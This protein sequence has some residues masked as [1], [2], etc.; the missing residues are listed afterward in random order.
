M[1]FRLVLRIALP[2]PYLCVHANSRISAWNLYLSVMPHQAWMMNAG[3]KHDRP[4]KKSKHHHHHGHSDKHHHHD[5]RHH[6]DDDEKSKKKKVN[7]ISCRTDAT[8]ATLP[9]GFF[10][11]IVTTSIITIISTLLLTTRRIPPSTGNPTRKGNTRRLLLLL[12]L[13]PQARQ[14]HPRATP[15]ISPY[16]ARHIYPTTRLLP[17]RR[18]NRK[19]FSRFA[20]LQEWTTPRTYRVLKSSNPWILRLE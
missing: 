3:G 20:C 9:A 2:F 6:H 11:N 1:I 5:H 18:A 13:L 10:R 14:S 15:R 12:L 4:Q 17:H 8:T 7:P 19:R 16:M